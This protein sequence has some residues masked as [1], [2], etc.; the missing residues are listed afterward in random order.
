MGLRQLLSML[1]HPEQLDL[2]RDGVSDKAR[3]YPVNTY[4]VI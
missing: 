4:L 1:T 2:D 3:R